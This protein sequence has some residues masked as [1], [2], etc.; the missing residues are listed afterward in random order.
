M[1]AGQWILMDYGEIIVQIF[2]EPVRGFYDLE[3]LWIEAPRIP[4]PSEDSKVKVS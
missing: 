4:I 2:Y 1:E 3:G